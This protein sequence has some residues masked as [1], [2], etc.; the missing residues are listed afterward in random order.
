MAVS[1]RLRRHPARRP[2]VLQWSSVRGAPVGGIFLVVR[3]VLGCVSLR[4]LGRVWR[5][6]RLLSRLGKRW[7]GGCLLWWF[8]PCVFVDW[9]V[10]LWVSWGG[11]LGF[12]WFSTRRWWCCVCWGLGVCGVGWGCVGGGCGVG[13]SFAAAHG[14]PGFPGRGCGCVVVV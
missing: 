2:S 8:L 14:L 13:F 7:G 9:F 12:G 10:S 5:G 6:F 11:G 3:P 1:L 4:N